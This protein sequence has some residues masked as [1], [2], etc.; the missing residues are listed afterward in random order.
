MPLFNRLVF[1]IAIAVDPFPRRVISVGTSR[2]VSS[3]VYFRASFLLFFKKIV[4]LLIF[5]LS[6]TWKIVRDYNISNVLEFVL[7]FDG[8]EILLLVK[9]SL[10]L[11]IL[12]LR[13]FKD[14]SEN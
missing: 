12:Y 2:I 9:F 4:E 5:L 14:S 8:F 6:N 11:R 1:V 13:S 10:I 3:F 7:R